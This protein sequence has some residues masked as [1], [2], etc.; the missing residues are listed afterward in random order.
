MVKKKISSVCYELEDIPYNKR[1]RVHRSF[2]THVS[3]MKLYVSRKEVDWTPWEG[4]EEEEEVDEELFDEEWSEEDEEVQ[5]SGEDPVA[6]EEIDAFRVEDED[7]GSQKRG[8]LPPSSFG[9]VRYA[10]PR[11]SD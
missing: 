11:Y 6:E 4:E 7:E 5:A 2:K 9:R 10:N 8:E 3:I 1:S